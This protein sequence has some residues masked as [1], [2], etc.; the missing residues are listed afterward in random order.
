MPDGSGRLT[1][2]EL[3]PRTVVERPAAAV[4]DSVPDGL[5]AVDLSAQLDALHTEA[6]RQCFIA[7]SVNFPVEVLPD[8]TEYRRKLYA[9]PEHMMSWILGVVLTF[10]AGTLGVWWVRKHR[11][12]DR[13]HPHRQRMPRLVLVIA[14]IIILA[15]ILVALVAW[16]DPPSDPT[17]MR[18]AAVCMILLPFVLL[19]MYRNWYVDI[20]YDRIDFR[21]TLG[22]TGSIVYRDITEYR[23]VQSNHHLMLKLRSRQGE[24]I[25][26]STDVY[27]ASLLFRAKAFRD[28]QGRWPQEGELGVRGLRD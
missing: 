13:A 3:T 12:R 1:R 21:T 20:G 8:I 5:G 10:L 16:T 26:F 7:N 6:H 24:H 9:V 11:Q 22:R 25:Q 2:A 15:G 14:W 28:A 18:I 4:V 19:W 27:D 17:A 23:L